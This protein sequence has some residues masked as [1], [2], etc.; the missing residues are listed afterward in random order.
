MT[1]WRNRTGRIDRW[2]GSSSPEYPS[3]PHTFLPNSCDARMAC[4]DTVRSAF[5]HPSIHHVPQIRGR[6]RRHVAITIGSRARFVALRALPIPPADPPCLDR[7]ARSRCRS[8]KAPA[9]EPSRSTTPSLRRSTAIVRDSPSSAVCRSHTAGAP[10]LR[11]GRNDRHVGLVDLKDHAN[12]VPFRLGSRIQRVLDQ[13]P[14]NSVWIHVVV[15]RQSGRPESDHLPR[16]YESEATPAC[17]DQS[18]SP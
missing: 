14:H 15:C 6:K 5:V 18:S 1:R 7:P 11:A 9:H 2:A 12:D 8:P 16:R 3:S 13:L 10:I 17:A 4:P